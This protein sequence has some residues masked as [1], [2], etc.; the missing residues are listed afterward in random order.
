MD[1]SILLELQ[2]ITPEEQQIL[3]GDHHI[4]DSLYQS[5]EEH[6]YDAKKLL[7]EGKLIT[8]RKHTRFVHFP[9]HTHNYVEVIYVCSGSL[10]HMINGR[11][12]YLKQGELLFL[13]QNAVQEIEE[14]G[15]DDLAVNFIILPEFFD[16]V[17]PM[18]DQDENSLREFVVQCLKGGKSNSSFIHFKVS[19]ILPI[20]N[21]VENL[22]WTIMNRQS[23][24]RSINQITMGLLF[25][26]LLNYAE[27]ADMES[28]DESRK[29]VMTVL[30]YIEEHY[31]DGGLKELADRLHYNFYW[32]SKEIK[33]QTGMT[34]TELLQ[35][36]R[37]SQA[38]YLLTH[39][40]MAVADVGIAVGYE[41]L[42]Y[43]HRIFQARYGVTPKRYRNENQEKY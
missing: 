28:E 33:T 41:N 16:A 32:L 23:N 17:L 31:R 30:R 29:L 20:Q 42:S 37:L 10:H 38:A 5:G 27:A 13:S 24:K 2:K 19:E 40:A 36:K 18:I 8:I 35:S 11:D 12:V 26:Q 9:P 3:D 21:L 4:N 6:V 34:Y 22:I 39:T 7:D 15:K 43:F 25:L 14:A 1:Q